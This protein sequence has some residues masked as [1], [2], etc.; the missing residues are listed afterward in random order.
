MNSYA[1]NQIGLSSANFGTNCAR[2]EALGIGLHI[3]ESQPTNID[4][5]SGLIHW[6]ECYGDLW[7]LKIAF[8]KSMM[9]ASFE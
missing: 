4:S 6:R 9:A 3:R 2:K 5:D 8:E 7:K 1:I